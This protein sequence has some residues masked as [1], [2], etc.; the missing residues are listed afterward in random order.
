MKLVKVVLDGSPVNYLTEIEKGENL[1]SGVYIIVETSRG[2]ELAKTICS[3]FEDESHDVSFKE[4]AI[5]E[6]EKENFKFVK[7]ATKKEIETNNENKVEPKNAAL[8]KTDLEK[9]DL[10]K[11]VE[12]IPEKTKKADLDSK[13][14]LTEDRVKC[15]KMIYISH[16]Y[17]GSGY[18]AVRVEKIMSKLVNRYPN[19]TFVSPIHALAFM[20]G[21]TDYSVGLNKCLDILDKCD[22]MWVFDDYMNSKGCCEEINYCKAVGKPYTI[23]KEEI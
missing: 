14:G 16:R 13:S 10:E 4:E 2:L 6:E 7:L 11:G 3:S 19:Y 22:E 20:Y 17:E 15:E 21:N 9:K 12:K 8:E 18:R 5:K 23:F 1:E